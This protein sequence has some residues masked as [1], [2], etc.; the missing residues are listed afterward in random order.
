MA[1]DGSS[2]TLRVIFVRASLAPMATSGSGSSRTPMRA[3]MPA[4]LPTSP[5][6]KTMCLR[7]NID[8]P[9]K[10]LAGRFRASASAGADRRLWMLARASAA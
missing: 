6:A 1:L 3:S 10:K 4:M 7:T 9:R 8:L 2:R 5:S